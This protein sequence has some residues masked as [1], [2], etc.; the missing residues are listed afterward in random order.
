VRSVQAIFEDG[1]PS[2]ITGNDGES[3]SHVAL[4]RARPGYALA[5]WV[6]DD[7]LPRGF[8]LVFQ[9]LDGERLVPDDVYMGPWVGARGAGTWRR[10]AVSGRRITGLRVFEY[11][12]TRRI[13]AVYDD[14]APTSTR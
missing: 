9:R 4:I 5:G 8:A 6:V 1:T 7:D 11:G 13:A 12:R 10:V 14:T 2:A 3:G